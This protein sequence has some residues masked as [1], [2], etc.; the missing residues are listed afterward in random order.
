MQAFNLSEELP[1]ILNAGGPYNFVADVSQISIVQQ[2]RM[3]MEVGSGNSGAGGL[4]RK[5]LSPFL[6]DI[7]PA[8]VEL[9][10]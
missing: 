9:W 7:F 1:S 8:I 5:K 3:E 6:T 2:S 10:W 4:D